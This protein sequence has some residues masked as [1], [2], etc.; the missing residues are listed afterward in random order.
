MRCHRLLTSLILLAALTPAILPGIARAGLVYDGFAYPP[1]EDLDGHSGGIGWGGAW[2]NQGG[3]PT[4]TTAPGRG[5]GAL[6]VSP[7]A[8][9]TPTPPSP[10][11]STLIAGGLAAVGLARR[12]RRPAQYC[13]PHSI[14]AQTA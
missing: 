8:A 13:F 12:R 10:D 4:L 11:V 9:S 1:G 14:A 6:A 3:A 7:G 5:F 2:F